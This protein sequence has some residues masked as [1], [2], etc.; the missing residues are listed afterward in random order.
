MCF[1]STQEPCN[2]Q[3][4]H[5]VMLLNLSQMQANVFLNVSETFAVFFWVCI[6]AGIRTQESLAPSF[7]LTPLCLLTVVF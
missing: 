4:R 3:V 1:L 7:V 5:S 2:T 6:Q